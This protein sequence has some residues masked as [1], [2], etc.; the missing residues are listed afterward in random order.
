MLEKANR[1]EARFYYFFYPIRVAVGRAGRTLYSE[2]LQPDPAPLKIKTQK[3][4]IE[5][6]KTPLRKLFKDEWHNALKS[7]HTITAARRFS[8]HFTGC[9][10]LSVIG[11]KVFRGVFEL[12]L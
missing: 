7:N 4:N 5:I 1:V 12:K 3:Q 6:K 10:R 2:R 11:G 8:F 9:R